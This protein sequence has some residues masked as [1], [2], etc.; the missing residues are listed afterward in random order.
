M[1]ACSSILHRGQVDEARESLDAWKRQV[2]EWHNQYPHLLF[3]SVP[4]LLR[5]H[6]HLFNAPQP[7]ENS[8]ANGITFFFHSSEAARNQLKS[9]VKVLIF[10]VCTFGLHDT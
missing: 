3:F 1:V 5:L 2:E 4:K 6:E 9:S 8:I 10:S 7:D